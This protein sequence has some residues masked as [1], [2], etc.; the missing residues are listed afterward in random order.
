LA[1]AGLAS[2]ASSLVGPRLHVDPD[3]T[4]NATAMDALFSVAGLGAGLFASDRDNVATGS[5]LAAGT[6]GLLLGGALHNHIEANDEMAPLVTLATFEGAF[7]GGF[8]PSALRPMSEVT[9]RQQVGGLLA[10]TF[11]G[12]GLS[13]LASSKL[14]LS[15]SQAGFAGTTSA[16]GGALAGGVA[17]VNED[18]SSQ[19]KVA[20]MLGGT[21][22]GLVGG[23]LLGKKLAFEANPAP[24]VAL[25]VLLGVAEG[26]T[27]AWAG[28]AETPG[29][30]SC[31]G[32]VGAGVGATL[33]LASA[34][35]PY[36]TS[37][38]APATAGFAAWGA[39]MGS[40]TGSLVKQD[41]RN[42]TM[43]GLLGANVGALG[44]YALVRS[45]AIQAADFGWLSLFGGIGTVIGGGIGAPFATKQDA[46]PVLAGLAIGPAVGL[47]TGYF[48]LP[49]LRAAIGSGAGGESTPITLKPGWRVEQ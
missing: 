43:G 17:L 38:E 29:Q 34:A 1:G 35:Y 7:I 36:F 37:R 12:A 30:W 4:I 41:A 23:A 6:A 5:M 15:A 16:V 20:T 13:I 2:F 47:V 46:R 39:W 19:A 45:G 44:G 49:K 28:H 11:T 24:R 22:V 18:W 26:L 21:T 10:G 27:F 32:L 40:F 14:R 42:V 9:T 8:L 48:L 33:G 31:A 3:L 25:G